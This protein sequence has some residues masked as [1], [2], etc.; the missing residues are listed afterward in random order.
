[1]KIKVHVTQEDINRG[2]KSQSSKCPIAL[3]CRGIPNCREAII[4]IN[5]AFLTIG[6]MEYKFLLPEMAGKFVRAF[7]S[8]LSWNCKPFTFEMTGKY[9]D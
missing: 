8:G 7:D 2:M 3:A 9:V 5:V 4:G 6:K 1:M